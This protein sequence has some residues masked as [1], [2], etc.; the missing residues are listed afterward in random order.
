MGVQLPNCPEHIESF[1]AVLKI[2]AILVPVNTSARSPE[3]AYIYQDTGIAA[4]IT[5]VDYLA[6]VEEALRQANQVTN[7]VVVSCDNRQDT[8]HKAIEA[9]SEL[10]RIEDTDNDDIAAILY[11]AGTTGEPKGVMLEHYGFYAH[12][13]G[14][15]DTMLDS[16]GMTAKGTT[17]T[18][19]AERKKLSGI[20]VE[21][22]GLNRNRISLI[23]LPLFHVYGI[24]AINLELL[25]G[26]SLVLLK[27]W[28]PEEAMRL[29][30]QHDVSIFRGVPT[31]YIQMLNHPHADRYNLS[32]LQS[33]ISGA[34]PLP[35][36]I[37]QRWKRKYNI[38][39]REGYGLTEAMAANTSHLVDEGAGVPP[40]HGS[41]GKCNHK[42]NT[43]KIFDEND[44]E[45]A[46]GEE[47]EIVI[48]GLTMMKGYWNKPQETAEAIR[49][50]WLHT[51]D[52]G[53]MDEDGYL[54]LTQR[55]NDLIIRGGENIYPKEVEDVLC[56]H[57]QVFEVVVVGM[58]DPIYG[59]EV[60]AFV[61]V[62]RGASVTEEE[63]I[64]FCK[65]HLPTYKTPKSIQFLDS[66]PKNSIGKILRRELR[67]SV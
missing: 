46:P 64:S 51:G 30:E 31:M 29:I 56:K 63:L 41:V 59:E 34:A 5:H 55:K 14:F 36:E 52:I 39:I 40:K 16:K 60:K 21:V 6:R 65:E 42:C 27:H 61:T 44:Q 15:Y 7:I 33:C 45:M 43:I 11:T 38:D 37:A 57:P 23:A 54:Y 67:R 28:N 9:N 19:K 35:L 20:E 62:R 12:T 32:S 22:F 49:N 47:G 1:F 10:L 58:P 4:L 53:Y 3:L 2:G 66:L 48:K 25:P 18:G 26:G 50:G 17:Q 13:L 24:S 8:Y